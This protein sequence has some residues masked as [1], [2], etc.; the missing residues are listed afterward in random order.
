MKL[1]GI[2]ANLLVAQCTFTDSEGPRCSERRFITV[3]H[4]TPFARGGA[5]TFENLCLLCSPTIP[6]QRSQRSAKRCA[7]R[8]LDSA[9]N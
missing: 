5:P 7:A 2:D 8:S 6:A 1:A 9:Q 4:K 3:E